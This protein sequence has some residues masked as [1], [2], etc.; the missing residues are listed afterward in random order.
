MN[1]TPR[2]YALQPVFP[3]TGVAG[4]RRVPPERRRPVLRI[5]PKE[6]LG[7]GKAQYQNKARQTKGASTR[8]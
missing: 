2:H 1:G 8:G 4:L 5:P 6:E 3:L 7:P